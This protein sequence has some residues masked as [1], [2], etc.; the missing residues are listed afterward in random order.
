LAS[1]IYSIVRGFNLG[2]IISSTIQLITDQLHL[3]SIPLIIYIDSNSLYKYLIKL[4][5]TKKKHLII[6]IIAL[7]QTYKKK[8]L[9][10]YSKLIEKIILPTQ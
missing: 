5:T 1:K 10:K 2:I 4:E 3:P 7:Y 9:I 6:N 8:R